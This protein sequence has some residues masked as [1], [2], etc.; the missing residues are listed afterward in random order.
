[1]YYKLLSEYLKTL[2][3]VQS[4][5]DEREYEQIFSIHNELMKPF[6]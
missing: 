1:M 4:R 3:E 5:E 2:K 6:G